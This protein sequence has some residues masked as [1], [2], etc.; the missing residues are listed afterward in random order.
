MQITFDGYI[1]NPM[2]IKNSVFS[3]RDMYKDLY[4]EK[5]NKIMMREAGK[6]TYRLF[7]DNED[8][9]YI[10]LKIPSEVVPKF[11]YDVVVEFY[12]NSALFTESRN[13][14][15]YYVRF[16]SNDPSF[17]FTFC[18]AFIDN[19]LFI[20][21]L[22]TRMSLKARKEDPKEK[23]PQKIVGYVKSLY[24][25]YIFIKN[26]GLMNKVLFE[27]S[28][29]K[30]RWQELLNNI[31]LA[32]DKITER[33]LAGERIRKAESREKAREKAEAKRSVQDD[34]SYTKNTIY[35]KSTS[36]IKTVGTVKKTKI[37]R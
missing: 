15:N 19:D 7:T 12:T 5:F 25:A 11:Y 17:V 24:F 16:Y 6:L 30:L 36:S 18:K 27:T 20:T 3:H 35:T 14:N 23:N 21:Q 33:Q 1:M 28:G 37:K 4:T 32:D 34:K 2:G 26:K 29:E 22:S 9:Y 13:L 8:K 10:Y 31:A